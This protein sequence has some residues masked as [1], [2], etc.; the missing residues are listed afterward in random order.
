[1]SVSVPDLQTAHPAWSTC[2]RLIA[3]RF[4][5]VTLFDEIAEP[6]DL[7]VI[8][9]IE[10]MTNP[11]LRETLGQLSL[12]PVDERVG[13]PG[14]T[15]IMAAFTHLNPMG[16]RFSDG[17]YGV[18]Y[19]AESLAT[20]VAE[21]SHHRGKFLA[22]TNEPAI[23][24]DMR[25]VQARLMAPLHDLRDARASMPEVYDR[26]FYGNSQRLGRRLREQGS[27][28]LIYISV[29]REQGQCVAVFRPKTLGRAA[30]KGHVG[31]HWNG[32]RIS[33]WY[34]KAEPSVL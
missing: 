5:T 21:V 11:R 34:G 16:S 1:M 30:A 23:D 22:Q 13:G 24:F 15:L 33:H 31:F 18:Y 27:N 25:W 4:P 12:V 17:S 10:S 9:A 26:D 6:T 3:S 2:H 28:G 19:A 20:A 7:E 29:R 14:S 8:Y 32:Q